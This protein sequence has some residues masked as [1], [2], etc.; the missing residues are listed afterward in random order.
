[1]LAV[2]KRERER[3]IWTLKTLQIGVFVVSF[4][5]V[6]TSSVASRFP[7]MSLTVEDLA[8]SFFE[9]VDCASSVRARISYGA[10]A[11]SNASMSE[12]PC[13]PVA[14]VMRIVFFFRSLCLL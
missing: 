1:M 9:D 10:F 5:L 14:P 8:S 12:P 3:R 13:F 7:V 2:W 6:N 11:F 4:A